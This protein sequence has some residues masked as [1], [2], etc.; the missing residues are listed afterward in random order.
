MGFNFWNCGE[1][2]TQALTGGEP[3][4]G[5]TGS[6]AEKEPLIRCESKHCPVH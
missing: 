3:I 6:G 1:V 4:P 5:P 2:V